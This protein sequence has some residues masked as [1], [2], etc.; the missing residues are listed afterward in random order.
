MAYLCTIWPQATEAR[1]PI[2]RS[3]SHFKDLLLQHSVQRP[4]RSVG[5]FTL[6]VPFLSLMSLELSLSFSVSQVINERQ[7]KIILKDR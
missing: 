7:I 6:E 3:F 2:E 4:P 1:L 5:L